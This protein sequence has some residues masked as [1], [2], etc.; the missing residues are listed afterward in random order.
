MTECVRC[1]RPIVEGE[2]YVDARRHT[3]SEHVTIESLRSDIKAHLDCPEV[4]RLAP[5]KRGRR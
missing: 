3:D 1:G 5:V 4:P 2:L